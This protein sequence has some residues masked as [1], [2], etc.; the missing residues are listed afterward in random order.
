MPRYV[1]GTRGTLQHKRPIHSFDELTHLLTRVTPEQWQPFYEVT[2]GMLNGTIQPKRILKRKSLHT[3]FKNKPHHL[4]PELHHEVQQHYD[5][6][7]IGGGIN[8]AIHTVITEVGHL[9]GLDKLRDLVMGAPKAMP[10]SLHSE[11]VAYLLH[12][13]YK[14]VSERPNETIGYIRLDEFDRDFISVFE[15]E[16]TGKLLVCVRGS[17]LDFQSL[18]DDA[19][20]LAG[21]DVKSKDLDEVLD[22]LEKKFPEKKYDISG[23][24]LGSTYILSELAEH[25]SHMDDIMLY[26]PGSSPFQDTK[27]L[28]ELANNPG[29]MWFVNRGDVVSHG[30]YQNFDN[31]TFANNVHLSPYIYSPISAHG[32]GQWYDEDINKSDELEKKPDYDNQPVSFE[33]AELGQDTQE[34]QEK[35]LS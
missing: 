16:K 3:I 6:R 2:A 29:V 19:K 35:G 8:E 4:L 7:D 23:H 18:K 5:Q 1:R 20:I 12:Q 27:M 25:Q 21:F 28:K 15:N 14:P 11:I 24:S 9:L 32:I 13:V 34:T 10:L 26:N 33:T 22:A 30:L 31:V 17:K